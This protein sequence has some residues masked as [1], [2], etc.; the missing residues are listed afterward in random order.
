MVGHQVVHHKGVL[1]WWKA[2]AEVVPQL[3]WSSCGR[4][5]VCFC[6]GPCGSC[7]WT[8]QKCHTQKGNK[9]TAQPTESL[10]PVVMSKSWQ[11]QDRHDLE[12]EGSQLP[13]RETWQRTRVKAGPVVL[14]LVSCVWVKYNIRVDLSRLLSALIMWCIIIITEIFFLRWRVQGKNEWAIICYLLTCGS[15]C[16]FQC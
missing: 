5:W 12:V 7:L 3:S 8:N 14:Q 15:S 6:Q 16:C 1:R 10:R 2:A 4:T 13:L 11:E 9:R